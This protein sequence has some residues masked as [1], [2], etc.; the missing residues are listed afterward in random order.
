MKKIKSI[1]KKSGEPVG[2]VLEKSNSESPVGLRGRRGIG[3][4]IDPEELVAGMS[5]KEL[6]EM[7][8]YIEDVEEEFKYGEQGD[9]SP[10]RTGLGPS[11]TKERQV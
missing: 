1:E 7:L 10:I 8:N 2:Y 4:E 6:Q 3:T 9:M 5:L 11:P